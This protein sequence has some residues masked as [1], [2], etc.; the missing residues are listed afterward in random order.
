MKILLI[1]PLPPPAGGIAIWTEK[2]MK[3]DYFSKHNIDILNTAVVGNRIKNIKKVNYFE[4]FYRIIVYFIKLF[5]ILKQNKYDIIHLNTS[6]S[7]LGLIREVLTSVIVKFSKKNLV[8]HVRCDA[9]YM[10]RGKRKKNLYSILLHMSNQIIVLNQSSFEFNKNEFKKDSYIL[11]NFISKKEIQFDINHKVIKQKIE[12]IIYVGHI[13]VLKGSNLIIEAAK[14]LPHIK[15]KLVGNLSDEIKKISLPSNVKIVNEVEKKEISQLLDDSD[16]F[17]FPTLTEGFPNAL[18]EAMSQGLPVISTNVGAIPEMLENKG[19]TIIKNINSP[20]IIRNIE[21]LEKN[22]KLRKDMSL[23]NSS[24]VMTEY[25]EEVVINR[26]LLIY[27][28]I[29]K[30]E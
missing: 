9:K 28:E 24:K 17:L 1:S 19:G 25:T 20:E 5:K 8:L 26:L 13:S 3:S 12:K 23:W 27:K 22:Y 29:I 16:L 21:I 6:C 11:P 14:S 4:E 18:L 15:F 30:G 2:V 7:G 10:V